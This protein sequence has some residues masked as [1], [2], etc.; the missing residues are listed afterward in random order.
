LSSFYVN[1]ALG[2]LLYN[3][4]TSEA[5]SAYE[6][7]TR[8]FLGTDEYRRAKAAIMGRIVSRFEPFL[9]LTRVE[10]G[11]HRFEAG[12]D[13]QELA[14]LV[15]QALSLLTPW[16]TLGQCSD[17]WTATEWSQDGNNNV[18]EVRASHIFIEPECYR[19]LVTAMAVDVPETKLSLP[20]FFMPDK[21]DTPTMSG[22]ETRRAPELTSEECEQVQRQLAASDGRRRRQQPAAL[23]VLVD[24]E[25]QG[26]LHLTRA[27]ARL[28]IEL[29]LGSHLIELRGEDPSGTVTVFA[30]HFITYAKNSFEPSRAT[31]QLSQGTVVF[32]LTPVQ[33]E[34]GIPSWASLEIAF[35][36]SLTRADDL[37]SRLMPRHWRTALGY[38]I[39]AIAMLILGWS[40]AD[41]FYRR[42]IETLR[43][44]LATAQ[45]ASEKASGRT[46]AYYR[47]ADDSKRSRGDSQ[48]QIPEISL[49]SSSSVIVL[50]MSVAGNE[51]AN[52]VTAELQTFDGDRTL[53][54]QLTTPP[55]QTPNGRVVR[56]LVPSDRFASDSYYTIILTTSQSEHRFSFETR[57]R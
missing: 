6:I 1:V 41:H 47:L 7:L 26:S 49:S 19:R 54:K 46:I 17:F 9:K 13:Q 16:S 15:N 24:G 57:R 36:P 48:S 42:E 50:E 51:E 14:P 29:K 11:E 23:T 30:T 4:T 27:N 22:P 21:Q 34:E 31:A 56:L 2:R 53:M 43:R 8:R 10:H 37:L 33:Q 52:P 28:P 12:D 20:R 32:D 40:F 44:D 38:L 25:E 18:T 3:Y 35:R 39:T 45:N 5:Q 55:F